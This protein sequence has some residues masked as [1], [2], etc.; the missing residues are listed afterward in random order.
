MIKDPIKEIEK[1]QKDRLLNKQKFNSSTA[2]ANI[3]EEMLELRGYDVPKKKRKDLIRYWN[4][5]ENMLK[6]YDVIE[7]SELE[8][9]YRED[10]LCDIIVFAI[11]ELMKLN[12]YPKGALLE[13]SKEIN[14]RM[15]EPEQ[16]KMWKATGANGKFQKWLEQPI[17]TLYKANF[18]NSKIDKDLNES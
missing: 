16:R 9:H 5:F 17:E 14:S 3:A 1:F 6:E 10:A 7:F 11:G 13:V 2:I 18:D 8:G 4:E 15:Q 12:Q